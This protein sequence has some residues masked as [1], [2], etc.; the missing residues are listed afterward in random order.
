MQCLGRPSQRV[1][2]RGR[3]ASASTRC[4][5]GIARAG[6]APRGTRPIVGSCRLPRSSGSAAATT[7]P[8]SRRATASRESSARCAWTGSSRR[9][10]SRSPAP[11]ASSRSSPATSAEALGL[12]PGLAAVGDHQ[13]DLGDGRAMKRALGSSS[14]FAALVAGC[15]GDGEGSNPKATV[16]AAASLTEV[17]QAIDPDATFSFAGS[18]EL[19]T[20]IREGAP[21]DVYAAASPLLPGRALR[22]GPRRGAGRLRHEQA[23]AHRPQRQPGGDHERRGSRRATASSS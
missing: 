15:G 4:G 22:G 11:S 6:S 12:E 9:S 14:C 20:Q 18:D 16:F 3:S 8:R 23:R 19:A 7:T 1:R 21:A 2:P 5:A 13:G 10:S 17:F